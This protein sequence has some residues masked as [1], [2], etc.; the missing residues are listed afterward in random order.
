MLRNPGRISTK[1]GVFPNERLPDEK[2]K[3]RQKK[4]LVNVTTTKKKHPDDSGFKN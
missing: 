1:I 4:D 3:S 2:P